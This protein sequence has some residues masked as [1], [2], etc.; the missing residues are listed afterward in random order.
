MA[1]KFHNWR[2]KNVNNKRCHN[3]SSTKLAKAKI[4]MAKMLSPEHMDGKNAHT[5]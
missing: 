1:Y 3:F 2:K 5:L 4:Q